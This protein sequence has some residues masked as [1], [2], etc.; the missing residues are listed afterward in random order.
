MAFLS[1]IVHHL[2]LELGKN[3][4]YFVEKDL[5]H[6]IYQGSLFVIVVWIVTLWAE[7]LTPDPPCVAAH[8]EAWSS[9]SRLFG[10]A[11]TN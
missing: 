7:G 9:R 2:P 1:C 5:V 6:F 3:C 4:K 11:G 10:V 8:H